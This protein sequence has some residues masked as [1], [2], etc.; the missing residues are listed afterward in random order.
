MAKSNAERLR[1]IINVFGKYGYGEF[2]HRSF[3]KQPI[4]VSAENLRLAFEE[5]GPSFIKIGQTLATRNDLLPEPYIQELQK[6]QN[7]SPSFPYSEANQVF[8]QEFGQSIE[9]TFNQIQKT[10]LAT[11]SIAQVHYAELKDG[12]PIVIKIQRPNIQDKLIRDIDL[13]IRVINRLPNVFTEIIIDPIEILQDIRQQSLIELNFHLE[14]QSSIRFINNHVDRPLIQAP[15]PY[16]EYVSDKVLVQDY[17]KGIDM[18]DYSS[19]EANGYSLE[20]IAQKIVISFLHQVFDDGYYHADPH[21]GNIM[22]EDGKIVL[23]DFGIMGEIAPMH[24]TFLVDLMQALVMNDMNALTHLILTVCKA[25]GEIDEGEVYR[26]ISHLYNRYLTSGFWAMDINEMFQ[27][28]LRTAMKHHLTFPHELVLLSKTVIVIQGIAQRL[29]P[30]MDFMQLFSQ[31][32]ISSKTFSLHDFLN[33]DQL[34]RKSF[35]LVNAGINLP[36]KLDRLL[37]TLN[38]DRL[39]VTLNFRDIDKRVRDIN[40]M[41]NR[42]VIAI[43]LAAIIISSGL[44]ASGDT[45]GRFIDVGFFFFITGIVLA[46]Y[47][48]FSFIRSRHK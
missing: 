45:T 11:G 48:L 40:Q 31:Y 1:E 44:I 27:D 13:F 24:Q 26:D 23:I 28:V 25:H 19:L 15:K 2:Y 33:R 7:S 29:D 32:V 35:R 36:T 42:L 41:L 6:L 46:L 34:L 5:L 9:E 37:D 17:V 14:A 10:P 30:N 38:H 8:H 18:S 21:P 12:T 3:K 16:L 4:E 47:L 43:L 22:I 20:E 39:N